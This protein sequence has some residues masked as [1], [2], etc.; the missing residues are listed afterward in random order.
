MQISLNVKKRVTPQISA[1]KHRFT[2]ALNYIMA[3]QFATEFK[4][5][6]FLKEHQAAPSITH[7]IVEEL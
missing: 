7:R 2:T 4:E 3:S 5:G 6:N 1:G